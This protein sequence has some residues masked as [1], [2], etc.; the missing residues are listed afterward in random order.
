[1]Y[2]FSINNHDQ[3][4]L[5]QSVE[6]ETLNLKVVGSSPTS[7]FICFFLLSCNPLCVWLVRVKEDFWAA[8]GKVGR[9]V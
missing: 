2:L 3:A 8:D 6:R 5:A 7:G 9:F 4:W 1:M